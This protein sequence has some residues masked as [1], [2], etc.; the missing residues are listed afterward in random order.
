MKID[1]KA[2]SIKDMRINL[3]PEPTSHSRIVWADEVN[4]TVHCDVSFS[5]DAL[6]KWDDSEV[7]RFD[8]GEESGREEIGRAHV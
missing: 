8:G 2:A 1:N 7:V 4:S 5:E 3:L 6:Y